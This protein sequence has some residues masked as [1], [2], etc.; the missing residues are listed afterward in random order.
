LAEFKKVGIEHDVERLPAFHMTPGIAG[1]SRSHLR[2]I[3]LA[4]QNNYSNVLILEDDV[5]LDPNLFSI[6]DK[7][8]EQLQSKNLT[9]DI[10]YFSANLRG[11][12][13]KLIDEN[14]AHIV[15]AKAAHAYVVNSSV[16]DIILD[17][18]K[19]I[20]WE[21]LYNWDHTNPHRMNFDVWLKV[22]QD[23]GNVYGVYPSIAEQRAGYSDL[24]QTDCYYNLSAVYNKI[25]ESL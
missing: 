18:Y 16:Y 12:D 14:L 17:G 20:V 19:N 6:I 22:I 2:C 5:T 3:E 24:I 4:K 21:D 15:N 1:C 8:Y 10:L 13:N 23:R 25:L 7:A 9:Y 11:D